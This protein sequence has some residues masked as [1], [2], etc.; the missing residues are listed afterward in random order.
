MA[1]KNTY[2]VTKTGPLTYRQ[3]QEENSS[4]SASVNSPFYSVLR[5]THR[6]A[7]V[8]TSEFIY[9]GPEKSPLIEAG[10]YLGESMFDP[11]YISEADYARMQENPEELRAENQPWYAQLA[12][13]AAKGVLTFGTTFLNGTLGLIAG[14]GQGIYNLADD[15]ESTGFLQ[16]IWDN[17]VNKTMQAV[18]DWSEKALPN[19]YT[20]EEKNEPW[21]TNIFTANFL[22]DKFLKNIGFT[23]G[24]F[25]SGG[26]YSKALS[27]IG[28]ASKLAGA[29]RALT[30]SGIEA[31]GEGSIEAI[32][33]T[34]PW[35][36]L[37]AQIL[38]DDRNTQLAKLQ[39]SYKPRIQAILDEYENT[40]GTLVSSP[41]GR[42]MYDP[43]ARKRDEAL[44][45][46]RKEYQAA[47]TTIDRNYEAGMAKLNEDRA[48]MGNK[49]LGMN[50]AILTA[51]NLFQFGKLFANGFKTANRTS[52][53][54]K[55]ADGTYKAEKSAIEPWAKGIGRSLSEGAEEISQKAA[56]EVAGN[57]YGTDVMNYYKKAK[58][59]DA[60]QETLSWINSFSEGIE[61]TV[62]EGSSW[63]EFFIGTL[64]G[65]L[66]MPVFGKA[67]TQQAYLGKGKSVGMAGGMFDAFSEYKE[68]VQ[69]DTEIANA[70][71]ERVQDPKFKEYYQGMIRHY[72][73][74][75]E[76]DKATDS[77]DEFE[78]KNHEHSQMVNDI[79]MWDNAGKIE[80]L[81]E[82]IN[83]A[84]DTSPKN[85]QEIIRDT[86]DNL[87]SNPE[88]Q[89]NID[90]ISKKIGNLEDK[91]DVLGGQLSET[92]EDDAN[93]EKLISEVEKT[94][95]QI[96][97]EK[98]KL[99]EAE[100]KRNLFV[101]A[102]VD[103]RGN[104]YSQKDIVNKI[105]SNK[106]DI[107]DAVEL[108]RKTKQDID[109]GTNYTL[110]SEQLALLTWMKAHK[111]NWDNRASTMAGEV[112]QSAVPLILKAVQKEIDDFNKELNDM[113][114]ILKEENKKKA[115]EINKDV[116]TL[117]DIKE[118]LTKLQAMDNADVARTLALAP[119]IGN[120]LK[121]SMA[122]P[123][124][125]QQLT[126]NTWELIKKVDDIAKASNASLQ[127]QQKLMEYMLNP[128]ALNKDMEEAD[129]E[130][131]SE[132]I[133]K[134]TEQ[135]KKDIVE[136]VKTVPQMREALQGLG[137]D[138]DAIVKQ[139]TKDEDEN[140]AKLATAYQQITALQRIAEKEF[141]KPPR[142]EM[143][144]TGNNA[145][146][147]TFDAIVNE[148]D[149]I[150]DAINKLKEQIDKAKSA[151]ENVGHE[152]IVA[153]K[154]QEILDSYEDAKSAKKTESKD[155]ESK[156][157]A[158]EDDNAGWFRKGM[159]RAKE[160][161]GEVL[162]KAKEKIKGK[163]ED[164][165]DK[166]EET[167]GKGKGKEETTV[168]KK[169]NLRV[170]NSL[171]IDEAI[172]YLENLDVDDFSDAEIAKL[173]NLL[174]KMK[175]KKNNP[176]VHNSSDEESSNAEDNSTEKSSD[177]H[178][179]SW[180]WGKYNFKSLAD[181]AKREAVYNTYD[182]TQDQLAA[183]DELGAFDFVDNGGLGR[184]VKAE[185]NL[186]INYIKA[187]D[188][189]LAD[190]ILLAVE[191]T[192]ERIRKAKPVRLI[193]G[194]DGKSYQVVGVLGYPNTD[195]AAKDNWQE[196]NK[197]IMK[198][199]GKDRPEF[200]V[201]ENFY[202]K[203]KHI[204]SGRMVKSGTIVSKDGTVTGKVED[205]SLKQM[206]HG[207]QPLLGVYYNEARPLETPALPNGADVVPL[208]INNR[209]PREG[210]IWLMVQEADGRYYAKAV[211]VRRFTT[212]E[213][214]IDEHKDS[215]I[216]QQIIHDLKVIC[217]PEADVLDRY[218]AKYDLQEHLLYF[219]ENINIL[220]NEDVVSISGVEW[221]NDIGK[222]L[223]PEEKAQKI[224][225]NLQDEDLNLR[226]QI[227]V[228]HLEDKDYVQELLDSDVMT[229]DLLQAHNVNASFDLYLNDSETGEP[230][231]SNQA[232]EGSNVGHT[233]SRGVNIA[234]SGNTV[235][236]GRTEY[237][238]LSDGRVMKKNQEVTDP[239]IVAQV[240]VINNIDEGKVN[241]IEN[242]NVYL[243]VYDD[244]TRFGVKKTATSHSILEGSKLEAAEEKAKKLAEKKK[245]RANV[246]NVAKAIEEGKEEG[247]STDEL[248]SK[249]K[250][251]LFGIED[252][253]DSENTTSDTTDT[254][255][256]EEGGISTDASMSRARRGLFGVDSSKDENKDEDDSL[257]EP[258]APAKPKRK[259]PPI[260]GREFKEIP[261]RD[262]AV[263]LESLSR[264]RANRTR[265]FGLT[266]DGKQMFTKLTD[267]YDYVRDPKNGLSD[268]INTQED[269]NS[270]LNTIEK[271]R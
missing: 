183:M 256:D 151:T 11:D 199:R 43:A 71:N 235:N 7:F 17:D 197:A 128:Q 80:D 4:S 160:K 52:K 187:K 221:G 110:N 202:N 254:T 118:T 167:K 208:N 58:D 209:N 166:E 156:K 258:E 76:M 111:E 91:L 264:K 93:Y 182:K 102:F 239:K 238:L 161:A 48:K 141:V 15:D 211:K 136:N 99:K 174:Q 266:K 186:K 27:A 51:S 13:G 185:P 242:T 59:P 206:L 253:E 261:V 268:I 125:S 155:K 67:N 198:E 18:S 248:K 36:N 105:E 100:T 222:G 247:L 144:A 130:A 42:S 230:I 257:P 53:I 38:D 191:M 172:E 255:D 3:L 84:A 108:Y 78:F 9:E 223:S 35:Y 135:I 28:G 250:S 62:G 121:L 196:V 77:G 137:D 201:S 68:R 74:Q 30:A 22:G 220:F 122:R 83:D 126:G 210:S 92:S 81:I 112:K 236:I 159:K 195:V 246:K 116:K 46:L 104:P 168:K 138:H 140:I 259:G 63:E 192:K 233:G 16:G 101:G 66:G 73:L 60:E 181:R 117:M 85:I 175:E 231:E 240:K 134:Q 216:L 249:A 260:I 214:N 267:F 120:L 64:T 47:K 90:K 251:S 129:K 33:E 29:T 150:E 224:L 225:E 194:S 127:Y 61:K 12:A 32:N 26:L 95:K 262:T 114:E 107:L 243:G 139:L 142:N 39:D 171:P 25:Y 189:R 228:S 173:N 103:E 65:A 164:K 193:T 10:S 237:T 163:E 226:F 54:V 55:A 232:N 218:S 190:S 6:R 20:D 152:A 89:K 109:S 56:S 2:D 69:R 87:Q 244:G 170:L 157:K 200:F 269:F 131:V 75:K 21:Y 24:A 50:M 234:L 270:L 70:L 252:E 245:K 145:A 219:P 19:Y 37:H 205:R 31:A 180:I 217:N 132:Y 184:L 271:C 154:L 124:I 133:K 8:P 148:A 86:T 241:P 227:D 44:A 115:E 40:K 188:K 5:D 146:M 1:K 215:P 45:A 212:D 153:N 204:Y 49:I 177:P 119:Q 113:P 162:N 57:Y 123:D 203:V 213:Y 263:T 179:R 229:S 178:F 176:S 96:D 72:K 41:D 98:A 82:M 169:L 14:I 106:K 88:Y 265:I 23:V 147:Q 149:S 79:A 143:E 97:K 94:N 158:K 207:V 165:E 34:K